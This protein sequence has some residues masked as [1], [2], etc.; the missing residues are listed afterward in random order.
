MNLFVKYFDHETV[1]GNVDEA[2]NFLAGIDEI[3]LGDYQIKSIGDYYRSANRYPFRMKV[4]NINYVLFLKTETATVEDF[5]KEQKAL[6]EQK[7]VGGQGRKNAIVEYL[8]EEHVGWYQ[9]RIVFKRVVPIQATTKFKY[10]DV[11]FEAKLKA[12]SGMDCYNRVIE[13]LK[14]RQDLD[15]RCQYPSVKSD[16]FTFEFLG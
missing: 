3:N 7:I 1:V 2:V 10:V 4:S 13:H 8:N 11:E 14:N 16:R 12:T 6:K 9:A 5:Q 15:Q